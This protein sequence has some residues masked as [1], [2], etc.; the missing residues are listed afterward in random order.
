[1]RPATAV[2]APA[3]VPAHVAI[4]MD[5]N[6]R[7]AQRRRQP[8]SFG[9]RA[10]AK[11]ARATVEAAYRHGVQHLTLFAFSSENWQRPQEEVGTLMQLFLRALQEE[12]AELDEN[13]VRI[14][15]VGEHARFNDSLQQ[16]MRA[17]EERT[18]NNN[19][20][21]LNIAVGYGGRWDLAQAARRLAERVADGRLRPDQLD[22]ERLARE[23]SLADTPDPDLLIRTGG[24]HRISNF[25]I[26]QLAYTELY[27]TDCLWPDFRAPEFSAALEWYAQRE[28]RYG[29]VRA[30]A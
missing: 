12:V 4:I 8:R 20:L 14:R 6:G 9:H 13:Q 17:A 26:W 1:M 16:A 18:R 2:G 30:D 11:A 28:R 15:F 25:L 24:E 23:L 21:A 10:G 3:A 29:K 5:G 22:S 27:F 7:W 19:R